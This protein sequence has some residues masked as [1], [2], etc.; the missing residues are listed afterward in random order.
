[1]SPASCPRINLKW[2][3]GFKHPLSFMETKIKQNVSL[4]FVA[5]QLS[6]RHFF[7]HLKLFGFLAEKW[8]ITQRNI[9]EYQDQPQS[10]CSELWGVSIYSLVFACLCICVCVSVCS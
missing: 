6:T 7:P 4:C 3:L 1:M 8:K 2:L 10:F 5:S 9:K